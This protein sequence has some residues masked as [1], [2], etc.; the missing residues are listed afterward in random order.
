MSETPTGNERGIVPRTRERPVIGIGVDAETDADHLAGAILRAQRE[1]FEVVV[2]T[3]CGKDELPCVFARQLGATLLDIDDASRLGPRETV[4]QYARQEGFPGVVWREDPSNRIDY[5]KTVSELTDSGE[6][7]IDNVTS[8]KSDDEPYVL[9]GI[10]AFNEEVGIGSVVVGA[11]EYADDIVVV[12]DGSDDETPEVAEAAGATV[13]RHEQNRGKGGAMDSLFEVATSRDADVLVVLDGDGQHR[14]K[15]IQQVVDPVIA[16]EADIV[17]GSRYLGDNNEGETPLHRRVGQKVLDLATYA[18][19]GEY[20][21]DSQSGF[22][23]LSPD[24]FE[25]LDLDADNFSIESAMIN[26]AADAD[27]NIEEV[28]I[29]V[30][31]EGVPGAQTQNPL[32]HGLTVVVFLL[33]L[34]RDRHPLVFFGIPGACILILGALYG[35][36]GII[37]YQTTGTFY[38]VKILVSGFATIV[39][40]LAI[41]TG[42][43]LNRISH[44]VT[45]YRYGGAT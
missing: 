39:G 34:I 19:A 6:Y 18:I 36:Q 45:E 13:V 23:A 43:L 17:V 29:D 26:M 41:F 4:S 21:S 37:V 38:P 7:L 31:Y 9:A 22:R 33:Q 1:G 2:A 25:N 24:A 11:S 30:K 32:R 28:P 27:L 16:D 35:I 40:V 8:A 44:L 12:D 5:G 14:P 20:V 10:P 3:H 15:D 42:V